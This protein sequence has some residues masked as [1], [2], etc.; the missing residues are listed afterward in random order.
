[1][2]EEDELFERLWAN[3][4]RF[5]AELVRLG[6]DTGA[7]ET[8]ITPVMVGD[9]EAAIRFSDRLFEAGVFATSVVYP[10]VALD[11]ARLRAIVTAAHTDEH[12]D[13]ALNAFDQ[14]RSRAGDHRPADRDRADQSPSIPVFSLG[15]LKRS[16]TTV[17]SRAV[18]P[19]GTPGGMLIVCPSPRV[20][21]WNSSDPSSPMR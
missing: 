10:T 12:L 14:H 9:S 2:R 17:R 5:K 6:F 1:M 3:T 13:R 19:C 15:G 16:S 4:R 7:S 21:S 8:P 20:S 11:E 18:A